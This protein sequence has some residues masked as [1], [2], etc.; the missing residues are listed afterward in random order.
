SRIA[1]YQSISAGAAV[2]ETGTATDRK[3]KLIIAGFTEQFIHCSINFKYIFSCTAINAAG[4]CVINVKCI[5][6]ITALEDL[7]IG[8]GIHIHSAIG[9]P[10]T[11]LVIKIPSAVGIPANQKIVTVTAVDILSTTGITD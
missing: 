1:S 10:Y 6:R 3:G 9:N 5:N 4:V 8:K 11:V 2:N 7:N